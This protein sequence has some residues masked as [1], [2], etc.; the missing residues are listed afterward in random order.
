MGQIQDLQEKISELMTA[1]AAREA[2]DVAQDVV[3][4]AQIEALTAQ[5]ASLQTV[6]TSGLSPEDVAALSSAIDNINA[7]IASLNAADPTPPV[8]VP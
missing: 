2:R 7:V 4:T 5:V 3:T 8:V 6:P 1:E